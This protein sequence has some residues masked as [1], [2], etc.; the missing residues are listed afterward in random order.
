MLAR[1]A[2]DVVKRLVKER[3]LR[4]AVHISYNSWKEKQEEK[5]ELV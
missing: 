4:H 1:H 2:M 3:K 5:I